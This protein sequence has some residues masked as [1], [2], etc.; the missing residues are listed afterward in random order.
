MNRSSHFCLFGGNESQSC[1]PH[2]AVLLI[3]LLKR[4]AVVFAHH[5]DPASEPIPS[6]AFLTVDEH[7]IPSLVG[8]H[9]DDIIVGPGFSPGG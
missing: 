3:E 5:F 7:R 4:V 8:W 1:Q 6:P 9:P 2:H